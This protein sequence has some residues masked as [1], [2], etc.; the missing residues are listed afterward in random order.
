MILYS[1]IHYDTTQYNSN[2]KMQYNMILLPVDTGN[3]V[4]SLGRNAH[5]T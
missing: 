1:I 4:V 3:N 2:D 5:K